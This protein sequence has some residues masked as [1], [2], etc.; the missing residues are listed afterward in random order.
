[1][2]KIAI[3]SL[4]YAFNAFA[5]PVNINT[6]DA[7]TISDSLSGIGINKAESIV[8]YRTEKGAFKSPEELA[9]VKGIGE[10]TVEKNKKDILIK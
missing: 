9:N 3:I 4:L 1:M 10:K 2:K 6:A 7:K 8:K 5:T